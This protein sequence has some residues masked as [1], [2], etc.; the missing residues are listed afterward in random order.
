MR[1][2]PQAIPALNRMTKMPLFRPIP[3][4]YVRGTVVRLFPGETAEIAVAGNRFIARITVPLTRGETYLFQVA[5]TSYGNPVTLKMVQK[6]EAKGGYPRQI[7]RIIQRLRLF[8]TPAEKRV[9]Q[10]F[11]SENISFSRT[12]LIEAA[13]FYDKAA[14][15]QN[16]G[17]SIRFALRSGFPLSENVLSVIYARLTAPP[18]SET[19][20]TFVRELPSDHPLH[21]LAKQWLNMTPFRGS[22]LMR[23]LS[24][25]GLQ[26]ERRLRQSEEPLKLDSSLKP[27]LMTLARKASGASERQKMETVIRQLT[28]QQLFSVQRG[29]ELVSGTIQLPLFFDPFVTDVMIYYEGRKK[30]DEMLDGKAARLLFDLSL[31]RLGRVLVGAQFSERLLSVTVYYNRKNGIEKHLPSL[32]PSLKKGL[33][34]CG[35]SLTALKARFM[36]EPPEAVISRWRR[37]DGVDMKI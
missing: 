18:L 37:H 11:L 12:S 24:L 19:L 4:Q 26:Y 9:L 20:M 10:L 31:P 34:A 22:S 2:F 13:N 1:E 30:A 28:G 32:E 35:Y 36:T 21:L 8:G 3:G 6:L 29:A 16:A 25:L 23:I 5:S 15:E 7:D 17:Q 14:D 27:L 33:A